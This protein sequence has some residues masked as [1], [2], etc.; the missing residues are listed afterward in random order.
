MKVV[1]VTVTTA[2]IGLLATV[3][4]GEYRR[5]V[6]NSREGIAGARVTQ[7]V[8]ALAGET[9]ACNHDLDKAGALKRIIAD[10]TMLFQYFTVQV[11]DCNFAIVAST[12]KGTTFG[13]SSESPRLETYQSA[14]AALRAVGLHHPTATYSQPQDQ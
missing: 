11:D 3:G 10:E 9:L 7:Y 14:H 4:T 13:I 6:D 12:Q 1:D 5:H 8:T 2:L